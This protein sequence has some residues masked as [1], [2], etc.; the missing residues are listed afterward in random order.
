MARRPSTSES[1]PT[2]TEE[3]NVSTTTDAPV[4]AQTET[5]A[6]AEA[7]LTAFNAALASAVEQ[8]DETTGTLPEAAIPPV[9]A[10][11]RKLNGAK[12]KNAARKV[13]DEAMKSAMTDSDLPLAR[14]NLEISTHLT[15]GPV[16]GGQA[17]EPKAPVDPTQAFVELV[18]GLVLAAQLAQATVPEGVAETW[19]DGV[20]EN[21]RT[22]AD[23]A[24]AYRAWLESDAE[25]KGDEPE[26][27][28]F[29]KAAVKLALGKSAK[30]GA[31][32]KAS[33]GGGGGS[34][35][36]GERRDVA[37]HIESAFADVA[38]GTFLTVAEIRKH[39]SDE[40]GKDS[41]SAGAISARLFPKSGKVSVE[42]VTPGQNDK[43]VKGATKN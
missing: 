13:V 4:E 28:A 32:K 19:T 16:G 5:P 7:D 34:T 3:S 27:P 12:A 23:Q 38:S 25:D 2:P 10:E 41:P 36:E 40:Y 37:K 30:V 39:E 18:S 20:N 42:G 26:T 8:R 11:Y 29:V 35:Y 17:R 31:A 43:G 6:E 22:G 15:A 1:V 21:V 14:A 33:S 24:T 9:V